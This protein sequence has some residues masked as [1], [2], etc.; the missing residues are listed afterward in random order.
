M[1]KKYENLCKTVLPAIGGKDNVEYF[2]HCTT[3]LRFNI[4]DRGLVDL[5]AIENADKVLG[6]QWS[7]D[8]LQIII[9]PSVAEAYEQMCEMGGFKKEAALD[10]I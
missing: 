9:G 1:S 7:N 2:Q 5:N 10:E 6:T 4:K 3:R 8:E